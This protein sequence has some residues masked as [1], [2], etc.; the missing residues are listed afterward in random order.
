[1]RGQSVTR[2]PGPAGTA[3][4]HIARDV[5][6]FNPAEQVFQAM[7]DGWRNQQL[8]RN[9]AFTTIARREQVIQRFRSFTGEDPWSWT[10]GDVDEFF[11]ELRAVRSASH[12]TLLAYQN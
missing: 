8:S 2:Q 7:L 5:A 12:S 11:M 4:Q 1:M 6:L 3:G 10:V 9:L